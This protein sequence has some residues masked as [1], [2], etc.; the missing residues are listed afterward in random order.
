MKPTSPPS[1]HDPRKASAGHAA[2]DELHNDDTAHEESDINIRAV[3]SATAVIAAVCIVTAG[4]ML[5]LFRFLEG[6]A[7]ARDPRMSPL[8]MPTTQMPPNQMGSATFGGAPD[9]K[10]LTDEP[11]YLGGVRG[12]WQKELHTYGWIDQQ[13]GV[14]RIPIDRAKELLLERGLAVR[15]EPI[16][17]PRVGTHAPSYG[18]ASAG[19]TIT[20]P[21]AATA[22]DVPA[23]PPAEHK[24]AAEGHK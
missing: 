10:L 13:A 23:A 2:H 4:L 8:A 7:E 1:P 20:K 5:V 16:E 22:G 6:Q 24:P 19:R 17:D 3:L 11:R 21:V 18:E 9:P 14:A 15:A 12:E